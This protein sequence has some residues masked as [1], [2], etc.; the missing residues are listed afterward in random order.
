MTEQTKSK[1]ISPVRRYS[2]GEAVLY[3]SPCPECAKGCMS[4]VI[5][6]TAEDRMEEGCG[7]LLWVECTL[8][9]YMCWAY[10]N[11]ALELEQ[12]LADDVLIPDAIGVPVEP[13]HCCGDSVGHKP[14]SR[15]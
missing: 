12:M 4:D 5:S 14:H 3:R 10:K 6:L 13:C 15:R 7:R 8:C 1:F 2:V 11:E 9:G